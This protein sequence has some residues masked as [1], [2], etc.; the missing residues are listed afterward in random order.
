MSDMMLAANPR[1]FLASKKP[2]EIKDPY[3]PNPAG[4][5]T[6]E[7]DTQWRYVGTR[8]F[9]PKWEGANSLSFIKFTVLPEVA[10]SAVRF[11]PFR[12]DK[13]TYMK[14]D[15]E[16]TVVYTSQLSGCNVYVSTVGSDV[17][18]FHANAN[19]TKA[20]GNAVNN[21]TKRTMAMA[22][23]TRAGGTDWDLKLERG[24][25]DFYPEGAA[26]GVFFGQ[27]VVL[28]GKSGWGFYLLDLDGKI[29][30]FAS[31][32]AGTNATV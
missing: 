18:L 5:F 1:D 9:D 20:D 8:P 4:W 28:G 25:E 31:S 30:R 10:K 6:T 16:A 2:V 12:E 24:M 27:K 29:H 23:R 3:V 15:P 7:T 22:A 21:A 17:W 11:L 26:V 32:V 14:I 19:A 13:V